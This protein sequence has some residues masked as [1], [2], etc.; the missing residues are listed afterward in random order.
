M[1]ETIYSPVFGYSVTFLEEGKDTGG[2]YDFVRI[3]LN[4]GGGNFRHFHLRFTELFTLEHGSLGVE[5]RGKSTVLRQGESVFVPKGAPHRFF[6]VSEDPAVFTARMEPASRFPDV[7][8]IAYGLA[9]D[10]KTNRIGIP[11]NLL[12]TAYLWSLDKT[13][14][15]VA[16]PWLIG[17]TMAPLVPIGRLFGVDKRLAVYLTSSSVAG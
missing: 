10:G 2:L 16:P 5:L 8:R 4:P 1:S 9:R 15:A 6:S 13:A 7:L 11:R 17:L 3:E 14:S 12:H